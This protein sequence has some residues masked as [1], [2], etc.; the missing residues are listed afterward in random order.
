M[1]NTSIIRVTDYSGEFNGP[2]CDEEIFIT[3][4]RG[5]QTLS[6]A[7][8]VKRA[9]QNEITKFCNGFKKRLDDID[10]YFIKCEMYRIKKS[11]RN[12]VEGA[13]NLYSTL[14]LDKQFQ[15]QFISYAS[16]YD[17]AFGTYDD[18]DVPHSW[19]DDSDQERLCRTYKN[20]IDCHT[21][22]ATFVCGAKAADVYKKLLTSIIAA[23]VLVDCGPKFA[24]TIKPHYLI[25]MSVYVSLN[26]VYITIILI[27]LC[28]I[29]CLCR[30]KH[31]R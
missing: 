17:K 12:L 9:V 21:I 29:V 11:Y 27:L 30:R 1:A 7:E 2:A 3:K 6:P 5:V 13:N 20:I 24:P 18:C 25:N 10:T 26:L 14:C 19:A 22:K 8:L 28:L 16:C 23:S 15:K 31:K 4:L